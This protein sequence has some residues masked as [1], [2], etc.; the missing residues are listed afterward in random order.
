LLVK[1]IVYLMVR[2]NLPRKVPQIVS[3][4]YVN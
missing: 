2:V 3:L 4:R 1:Y